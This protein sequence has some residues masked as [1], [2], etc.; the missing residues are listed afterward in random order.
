SE[1]AHA[2]L[3][4]NPLRIL[5]SKDPRDQQACVGAPVLLDCLSPEDRAHW[6]GLLAALDRLGTPY[7]VDARLVRGLD[8]Y[9][10]TC[11]EIVTTSGNIGSQTAILGG[12]RY[13]G[14]LQS[15]GGQ[16]TPALGFALG[17]E[18]VLLALGEQKHAE[19]PLCFIAPLGA[20]A[21]LC[22]LELAA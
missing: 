19:P 6:D 5:D 22:C 14:M 16:D 3:L 13:D 18:R 8:Y 17:I 21:T 12:G 7:E 11:F 10:R 9:T 15:L 1:H 20:A 2:R 4:D